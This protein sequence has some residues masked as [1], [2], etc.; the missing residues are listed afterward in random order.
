MWAF[1]RTIMMMDAVE[2]GKTKREAK[3]IIIFCYGLPGY[4]HNITGTSDD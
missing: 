4:P 2:L 1:T 3:M